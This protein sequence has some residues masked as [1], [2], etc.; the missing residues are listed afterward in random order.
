MVID[1]TDWFDLTV[2][3]LKNPAFLDYTNS[4]SSETVS[5]TT[6]P[7]TTLVTFSTTTNQAYPS[8]DGPGARPLDLRANDALEDHAILLANLA[9]DRCMI[10]PTHSPQQDPRHEDVTVLSEPRLYPAG[11]SGRLVEENVRGHEAE[12]KRSRMVRVRT[13]QDRCVLSVPSLSHTRLT[14]LPLHHYP[15]DPVPVPGIGA[16]GTSV[17]F[18]VLMVYKP[19]G[20]ADGRIISTEMCIDCHSSNQ[21]SA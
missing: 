17:L 20:S 3:S 8:N 13:Q 11:C 19:R 7:S 4:E 10:R 2:V 6:S 12:G 18:R 16:F 15:S 9:H 5:S 21:T 14:H 1:L